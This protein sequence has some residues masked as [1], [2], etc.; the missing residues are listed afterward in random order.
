MKLQKH[1]IFGAYGGIG[2][3]LSRLLVQNGHS[4]YLVGRDEAKLK[5]LS[6]ELQQPYACC[7]L[8]DIT[9]VDATLVKVHDH[10][11]Q[12]DGVVNLVGSIVLKPAHLLSQQDWIN[13]INTNL[14]SA[15]AVVRAIAK[16]QT[17]YPTSVVL[18]STA[19]A[20]LGFANHE[21]ISAA[22][23]GVEGLMKSAACSYAK[24]A[25]RFNCVAP[26]LVHTGLTEHIFKNQRGLEYSQGLHP[27]QRLGEP[28]DIANAINF[29]LA[30]DNNWITGQVLT[31]DGG[32]ST[33]K[34]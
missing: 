8:T 11:G 3:A 33:L 1:L 14:T 6:A 32:L 17:G 7:D 4:V 23:S 20:H 30:A 10:I 15:F 12:V 25:L 19:A 27:L 2:Q 21:A 13:C 28:G 9:Q 22:K 34:Y 26:G 18:L 29:L 16:H 5:A 24:Q 31:V